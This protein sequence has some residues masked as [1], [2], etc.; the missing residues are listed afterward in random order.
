MACSVLRRADYDG[1][2]DSASAIDSGWSVP[3]QLD[4]DLNPRAARAIE[5]NTD[6]TFTGAVRHWSDKVFLR[7]DD[8][9][10][11]NDGRLRSEYARR[12]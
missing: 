4:S 11:C 5:C 6:Y 3:H 8:E 12:S 1:L 7:L 2:I 9:L 10:A